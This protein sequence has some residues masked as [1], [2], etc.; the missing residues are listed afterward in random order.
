VSFLPI[1]KY[2]FGSI[3]VGGKDY[4][5]DLIILPDRVVSGWRRQQGHSLQPKDLAEVLE[6]E[7]ELLVVGSG[8]LG[9]LSI[10]PSTR[11]QL[12]ASGIEI[13]VE[14]SGPACRT[15]NA[16]RLTRRVAAAIHLAC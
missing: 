8:C 12:R 11:A 2:Q 7:P 16:L 15:Y 3:R 5:K 13:I 10:P 1:E 14:R 6:A 4:A 9:R